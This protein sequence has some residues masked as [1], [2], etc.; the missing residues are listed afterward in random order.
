MLITVLFVVVRMV[1]TQG[2]TPGGT[3]NEMSRRLTMH[4][5]AKE[6]EIST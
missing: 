3:D 2:F 4:C 6:L 5:H 1:A